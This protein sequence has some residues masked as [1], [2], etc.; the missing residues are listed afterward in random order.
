M[1]FSLIG[2]L[3]TAIDIGM[4]ALLI[5]F[6]VHYAAAQLAAYG[7]GMTNSYLM[8]SAITFR[9]A[10]RPETRA[11]SW[12][13]K[14]RF[15]LWN[16]AMLTLS[17]ILL[18]IATELFGLSEMA[19]KA[20]VTGLIVFLNFYGSKKWVFVSKKAAESGG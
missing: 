19:A 6:N 4:F 2:L 12:S 18:S 13:R 14:L 17:I 3:N 11:E 5:S 16:G 1:K 9:T 10:G 20:V 7:A 15:L 8:N